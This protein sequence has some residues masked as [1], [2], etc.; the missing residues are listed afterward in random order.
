MTENQSFPSSDAD[1]VPATDPTTAN[2]P[3]NRE[4]N[5]AANTEAH[6]ATNPAA[7]APATAAKRR[8]TRTLL[9]TGGAVVAA[10]LLAGGGIAIGT[11]VADDD[12]DRDDEAAL[13]AD[14]RSADDS[15][16]EGATDVDDSA[17]SGA[18]AESG[19]ADPDELNEVIAA[20]AAVGDDLGVATAVDAVRGGG[21]DVRFETEAGDETK[22]RV[23]ADGEARVTETEA[24]DADDSAPAGT[25]DAATVRSLVDAA[26]AEADGTIVEIDVDG[27]AAAPYDVTVLLS[28]RTTVEVELGPDFAVLRTD[29][30]D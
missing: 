7:N 11:A 16:G 22:V 27:D 19:S 6:T 12:D 4:A 29:T 25:L 17:A 1:Q 8:R 23:S 26:L 30:D 28:D 18:A 21:W 2:T 24:A 9:V 15:A 20:A 14:D 5:T 13:V 3:T 10:A